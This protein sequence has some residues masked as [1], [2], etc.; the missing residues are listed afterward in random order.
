[1]EKKEKKRKKFFKF[2]FKTNKQKKPL[3]LP[4][5]SSNAI[6]AVAITQCPST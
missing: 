5:S 2:L 4:P 3:S 1:M 6:Y